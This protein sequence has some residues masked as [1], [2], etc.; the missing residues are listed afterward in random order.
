M[1]RR[2]FT[3]AP[4]RAVSELPKE[5]VESEPAAERPERRL[6]AGELVTLRIALADVQYAAGLTHALEIGLPEGTESGR[7]FELIAAPSRAEDDPHV[8]FLPW[9]VL[10][11]APPEER[12]ALSFVT[13]TAFSHG[14]ELIP[15]ADPLRLFASW[16]RAWGDW[17]G[18]ELD[19]AE[20]LLK[21]WPRM[22][23]KLQ[24]QLLFLR[25]G[26]RPGF[27]GEMELRWPK[28]VTPDVRKAAS[29]LARGAMFYST[30][31]KST[32]GMG[33]TR[34]CE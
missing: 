17:G 21:T 8:A 6:E 3:V 27:V 13:P 9:D 2:P 28:S 20:E 32:M 24:T 33:Q 4:L 11:N 12:L 30:G 31:A 14:D 18:P 34:V 10:I 29:A 23:Y 15:L 5:R 1:E 25:G 16:K 26:Q 19:G 7:R 22:Q